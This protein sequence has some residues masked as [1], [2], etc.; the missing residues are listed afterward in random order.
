[1]SLE[2]FMRDLLES[3]VQAW[4]DEHLEGIVERLVREEVRRR[5]GEGGGAE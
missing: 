2:A 1:M 4:L 3:K 5:S